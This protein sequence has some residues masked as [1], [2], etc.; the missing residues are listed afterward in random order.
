MN[1]KKLAALLFIVS[2]TIMFT[3]C[4]ARLL[5]LHDAE[6]PRNHFVVIGILGTIFDCYSIP[7][8]NGKWK[9][10]CKVAEEK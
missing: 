2:L 1:P 5:G 10:V 6:T 8:G 7:D 9:P 3:N 4:T